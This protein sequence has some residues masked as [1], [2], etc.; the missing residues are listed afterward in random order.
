MTFNVLFVGASAFVGVP[1]QFISF[2]FIFIFIF[3]FIFF[4]WQNCAAYLWCAMSFWLT[5][6][7]SRVIII[8]VARCTF[9]MLLCSLA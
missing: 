4:S 6:T 7:F 3:I 1:Q 8:I 2:Q 9:C 5:R